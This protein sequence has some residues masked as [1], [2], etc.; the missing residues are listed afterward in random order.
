MGFTREGKYYC[1]AGS[2]LVAIVHVQ[3]SRYARSYYIE[4]GILEKELMASSVP[5]HSAYWGTS[6]RACELKSEYQK[7]FEKIKLEEGPFDI[8]SVS[9]AAN[10]CLSYVAS[11]ARDPDMVRRIVLKEEPANYPEFWESAW[12]GSHLADWANG[13]LAPLQKY[14]HP[15]PIEL[16]QT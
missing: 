4:L 9:N 5:P 6:C 2:D 12:A 14:F 11:L 3:K 1:L 13:T 8:R 15:I 16:I 7:V 10:W